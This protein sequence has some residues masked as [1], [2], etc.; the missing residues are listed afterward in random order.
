VKAGTAYFTIGNAVDS[1][2]VTGCTSLH[3]IGSSSE[4]YGMGTDGVDIY[5]LDGEDDVVYRCPA[6]GCSGGPTHF[7]D[8]Q[9]SASGA[10]VAL[11]ADYVYWTATTQVLRKHR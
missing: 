2:P 7:A 11:D 3:T 4:P 5:W 1:C 9:P 6:L 8:N 10:T